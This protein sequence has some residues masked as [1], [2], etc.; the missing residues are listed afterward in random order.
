MT[1][2]TLSIWSSGLMKVREDKEGKGSLEGEEVCVEGSKE[3]KR[4]LEGEGGSVEGSKE[5]KRS[6]EGE[7]GSVEGRKEGEG[8]SEGK[9][10]SVE[11]RGGKFR[12]RGSEYRRN[13]KRW[14]VGKKRG[15]NK[16]K[17]SE[18]RRTWYEKEIM[19]EMERELK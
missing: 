8:S 7:G 10:G 15:G 13:V 11:G 4:S 14:K 6:L 18:M 2:C 17:K 16:G 1:E 12:K 3:G 19:K 9:G 5:G